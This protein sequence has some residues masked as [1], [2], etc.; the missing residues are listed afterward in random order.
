MVLQG[1]DRPEWIDEHPTWFAVAT[2]QPRCVDLNLF[3]ESAAKDCRALDR[4]S[5]VMNSR[6]TLQ[7][8]VL[9]WIQSRLIIWTG[10]LPEIG[11]FLRARALRLASTGK[12]R[13]THLLSSSAQ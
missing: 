12:T 4:L 9:P 11:R 7:V 13:L 8:G 5:P 6:A 3:E 2:Y 10:R 1:V